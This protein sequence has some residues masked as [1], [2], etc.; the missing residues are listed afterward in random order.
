MT[1]YIIFFT[2]GNLAYARK[3]KTLILHRVRTLMTKIRTIRF[4]NY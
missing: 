3:F 4:L 1:T 2:V